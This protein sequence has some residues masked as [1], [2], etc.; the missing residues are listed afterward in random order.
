MIGSLGTYDVASLYRCFVAMLLGLGKLRGWVELE[1][2]GSDSLVM[3]KLVS[4]SSQLFLP[5]F[6]GYISCWREEHV[7]YSEFLLDEIK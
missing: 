1:R 4:K 3:C 2:F 5:R 6:E 7:V